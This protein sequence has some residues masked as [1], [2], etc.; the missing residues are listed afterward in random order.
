MD[1][2]QKKFWDIISNPHKR[3]CDNCRFSIIRFPRQ[4]RWTWPCGGHDR[5]NDRR[6]GSTV[7]HYVKELSCEELDEY[8][9]DS[10]FPRWE[11]DGE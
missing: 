1:E 9:D 10:K 8:N 5:R 6:H 7:E 4:D 11:W 2:E 3:D